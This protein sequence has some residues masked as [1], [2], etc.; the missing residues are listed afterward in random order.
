MPRGLGPRRVVR[1]CALDGWAFCAFMVVYK[2]LSFVWVI[3]ARDTI[4][5]V[6]RCVPFKSASAKL[7][8]RGNAVVCEMAART[9]VRN[10][11]INEHHRSRS[12]L[13]TF[14]NCDG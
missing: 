3:C 8:L 14:C 9:E 1:R 7:C 12:R 5:C 2:S 11:K 13:R 6:L 10:E 4:Y